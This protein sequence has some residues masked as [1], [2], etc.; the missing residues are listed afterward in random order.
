VKEGTA[1]M[2]NIVAAHNHHLLG[3]TIV[4]SAHR[5]PKKI[6]LMSG[7]HIANTRNVVKHPPHMLIVQ[8]FFPSL[9]TLKCG[10]F[11]GYFGEER[12]QACWT[13]LSALTKFHIP[14][15]AGSLE[16]LG[17]VGICSRC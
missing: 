15:R 6:K 5:F 13:R 12:P 10:V 14:T 2:T 17:T 1:N 4:R 11:A 7:N 8:V 3:W 16:L 9:G